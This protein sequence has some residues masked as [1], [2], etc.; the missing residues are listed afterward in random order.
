M[1]QDRAPKPV[2]RFEMLTKKY[3]DFLRQSADGGERESADSE[4]AL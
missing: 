2:D 1:S 3:N 4:D